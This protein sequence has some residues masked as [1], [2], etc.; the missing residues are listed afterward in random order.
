LFCVIKGFTTLELPRRGGL[1]VPP[2]TPIYTSA[3]ALL[4]SVRLHRIQKR[5]GRLV[6]TNG[7]RDTMSII[8]AKFAYPFVFTILHAIVRNAQRS[9]KGKR[10]IGDLDHIPI[11]RMLSAV[12]W[13]VRLS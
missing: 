4:A 3:S 7:H 5:C 12:Y 1:E 8:P 9:S 10:C 13:R 2:G 11:R 6:T